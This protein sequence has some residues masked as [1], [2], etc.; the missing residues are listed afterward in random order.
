MAD[1]GVG[2]DVPQGATD[3]HM[4]IFGDPIAYPPAAHRAYDPRP[5][6]W[7]AYDAEAARMGF[8]R[9]VVVQPSAYG[10][11][12]RCTLDAMRGRQ[13]RLSWRRIPPGRTSAFATSEPDRRRPVPIE[14][15]FMTNT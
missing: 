3:C 5:M 15:P 9:V 7:D 8:S 2:F 13:R 10:T 6:G 11:D 4:H 1:I 14:D 12:N